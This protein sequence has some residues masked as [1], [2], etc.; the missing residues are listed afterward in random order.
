THV[1]LKQSPNIKRKVT[2]KG[3]TSSS[4]AQ[5]SRTKHKPYQSSEVE[6]DKEFKETKETLEQTI[7]EA[8]E[9]TEEFNDNEQNL[10]QCGS[11]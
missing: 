1:P 9:I 5:G 6:S 11:P 4:C 10:E 2:S 7:F 3:Y 8:E